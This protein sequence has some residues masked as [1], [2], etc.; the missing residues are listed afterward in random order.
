MKLAYR[1]HTLKAPIAEEWVFRGCMMP[2]LV[3]C[4]GVRNAILCNPTFFGLG[5][6]FE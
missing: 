4:F 2:L 6:C 5:V 1:Q 3:P